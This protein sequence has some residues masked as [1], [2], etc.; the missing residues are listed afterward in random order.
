MVAD[1]FDTEDC[2]GLLVAVGYGSMYVPDSVNDTVCHGGSFLVL[3]DAKVRCA[4]ELAA[5]LSGTLVQRCKGLCQ[6]RQYLM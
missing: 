2:P 5:V 1:V 6:A 3:S 4:L